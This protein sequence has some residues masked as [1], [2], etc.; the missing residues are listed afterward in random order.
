[1]SACLDKAG[2][3]SRHPI[4]CPVSVILV[5][6]LSETLTYFIAPCRSGTITK[7]QGKCLSLFEM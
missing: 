7:T 4:F 3:P 5:T 6:Q 2:V 1:M